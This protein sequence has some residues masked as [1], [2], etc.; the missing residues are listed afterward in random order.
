MLLGVWDARYYE[1]GTCGL[2]IY[3]TQDDGATWQQVFFDGEMTYGKHFFSGTNQD[4]LYLCAGAGGGGAGGA[5]AFTPDEGVVLKSTDSGRTWHRCLAAESPT[6]VYDGI[7]WR[8][9][10]L[11]TARERCSVFR[12]IDDGVSWQERSLSLPARTIGAVGDRLI[13]TSDSAVF[14]STDGGETWSMCRAPIRGL[15]LR[16]PIGVPGTEGEIIVSAVGWRSLLLR[17]DLASNEW[18][19]AADFTAF[20]RSASM[21]R[22]ALSGDFVFAGDESASGVLMRVPTNKLQ[23]R[24][25]SRHRVLG[26]ALARRPRMW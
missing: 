5:V 9:S 11:V 10:V 26:Y 23:R 13:V 25:T 2:A 6:S 19:I 15:V 8:G 7:A 21:T 3:R 20:L 16:Y 1:F 4:E 18:F 22:L 14:V 24:S 17:V 12:S